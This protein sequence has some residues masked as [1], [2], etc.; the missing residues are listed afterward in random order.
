MNMAFKE[1]NDL[2]TN[3]T[4]ALGGLNKK[5]GKPNPKSLEGFFLGR[6]DVES[7]LSKNGL[8]SVYILKTPDGN[9]GVWGKTDMDRKMVGLNPGVLIRIS[10]TGTQKIPGKNDMYKYKVEVDE[11]QCIEVQS[12]EPDQEEASDGCSDSD[13]PSEPEEQ[14]CEAGVDEDEEEVDVVPPPRAQPPKKVAATPSADQQARVKALLAGK[15]K[16]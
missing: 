12:A 13:L 15:I 3:N 7:K 8:C 1:V 6:K 16:K 10:F 11:E 5:T 9:V 4:I 14:E 2:D